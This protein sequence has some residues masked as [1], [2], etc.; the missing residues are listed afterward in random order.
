MWIEN[1]KINITNIHNFEIPKQHVL[2]I[3]RHLSLLFEES[4]SVPAN[5]SSII[6]GDINFS[7]RRDRHFAV[8]TAANIGEP[9]TIASPPPEHYSTQYHTWND[10]LKSWTEISQP[11]QLISTRLALL[12]EGLIE[13]GPLPRVIC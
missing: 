10:I 8:S 13:S 11:F 3:G 6:I 4:R 12:F 5:N 1:A 9:S 7:D 2:G